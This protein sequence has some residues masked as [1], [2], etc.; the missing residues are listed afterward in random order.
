M[1]KKTKKILLISIHT[2]V[3]LGITAFISFY[4]LFLSPNITDVDG[5]KYLYIRPGDNFETVI[6]QL[7]EK[8]TIKRYTTLQFTAKH[9]KY[10]QNIKSGRYPIY[11]NEANIDFIRRLRSGNQEPLM[12]TFNSIRTK[13]QL[14]GRIAS[15]IMAD[16]IQ[17]DSLLNEKE[18]VA[19]Y[20]FE[21]H[22]IIS[23]FIPNSYEFFWDTSAEEFIKRMK[24]EYDA[25]WTAERLK[26]AEAISLTPTEVITLAS[27]VNEESNKEYEHPIIA[28]LYINR[29]KKGMLLQADPTVKFAVGDFSMRRVLK[30][31]LE[32]DSPYNTYKYAGLPPGPIRSPSISCIDGVLNYQK[33]NY[34]YMAAKETFN[35]EHN[36]ATSYNEHLRNA[37]KYQQALNTRKIFN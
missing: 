25:F 32:I 21:P 12:L 34:L 19:Q 27:I 1:D 24:R 17:I 2:L 3:I 14:A 18:F 5:F 35:G 22:T 11:N 16:S 26:K 8:S 37:R 13:S 29:I 9:L 15:Q 4:L 10:K 33:H 36:F 31:H 20:H 7:E 23:M 6:K 30:S 28:G